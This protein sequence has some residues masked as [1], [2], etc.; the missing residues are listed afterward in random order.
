MELHYF[1]K[2]LHVKLISHVSKLSTS[3]NFSFTYLSFAIHTTEIILTDIRKG[4]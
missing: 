4:M 3:I 2:I 1:V